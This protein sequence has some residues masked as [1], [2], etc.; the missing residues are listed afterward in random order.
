MVSIKQSEVALNHSSEQCSELFFKTLGLLFL[1]GPSEENV[2]LLTLGLENCRQC[3]LISQAEYE[4]LSEQ[5][6]LQALGRDYGS[7]FCLG[8]SSLSLYESVWLTGLAMQEPRDELRKILRACSLKP[9]TNSNEP[10]DHLGFI[11]YCVG[12]LLE[13]RRGADGDLRE[14]EDM[15][16]L[17]ETVSHLKWTRLLAGAISDRHAGNFYSNIVSIANRLANETINKND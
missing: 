15:S 1:N 3:G 13:K 8:S 12:M 17:K 5:L 14:S 11:Y 7:L 10:E 2:Q 9:N 16:P 4:E 6:D